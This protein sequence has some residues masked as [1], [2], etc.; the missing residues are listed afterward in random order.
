[1]K[2][3]IITLSFLLFAT[4]CSVMAD[5]PS[6][7]FSYQAVVR[8]ASG[9]ILDNTQV[10]LRISI[11]QGTAENAASYTETHSAISNANGLV[12]LQVGTG[13]TL[14]DYA[15]I[16]WSSGPYFLKTEVDPAGGT[17]YT[18]S[19]TSQILSVPV[20]AYADNAPMN[21]SDNVFDDWDKDASDDFSGSFADLSDVPEGLS[22]G[23]DDTQ[24]TESQVD[25]YVANNGYLSTSNTQ[26]FTLRDSI[27]V[28]GSGTY[29]IDYGN[30][31]RGS[32]WISCSIDQVNSGIW[33]V[34]AKIV[35]SENS[36]T[37]DYLVDV[38]EF[39]Y[40]GN[41]INASLQPIGGSNSYDPS[42]GNGG[43]VQVVVVYI[44]EP[45][46][47]RWSLTVFSAK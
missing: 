13:T 25:A 2:K 6:Y 28:T 26:F 43:K 44:S 3:N 22:D 18:I 40:S 19:G 5:V 8:N 20:A 29:V 16:D 36:N 38:N 10:S 46:W 15:L 42:D 14:D 41:N 32:A 35:F 12:T 33:N 23:D 45:R 9:S 47:L 7:P 17:D 4:L 39:Q 27:W 1:M 30:D 21:G 11:I 31:F 37:K 34:G 24:L